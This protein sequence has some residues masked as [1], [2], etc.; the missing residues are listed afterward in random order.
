[1]DEAVERQLRKR[2]RYAL[3]VL[4]AA[5]LVAGACAGFLVGLPEDRI[6]PG[7]LARTDLLLAILFSL[8]SMWFCTVDSKLLGKPII[9]LAKL[10]IFLLWPIG[11]P[12]Y[13]LWA[14]RLRGLGLFLLHGCGAC[15]TVLATAIVTACLLYGFEIML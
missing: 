8:G 9:Q 15:L 14:H 12:V 11:V 13:L 7:F 6:P 2:P 4:Y 1:V 3:A 10:G 5:F